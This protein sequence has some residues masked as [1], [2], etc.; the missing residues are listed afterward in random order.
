MLD[1]LDEDIKE[2]LNDEF[3]VLSE[4]E[5]VLKRSN[6]YVGSTSLESHELFIDGKLRE[7]KYVQH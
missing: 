3:K 5:H 7:V 6:M 2:D 4:R 1:F